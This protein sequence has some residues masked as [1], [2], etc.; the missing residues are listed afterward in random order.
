M[1][2]ASQTDCL[3]IGPDD[4]SFQ[5]YERILR[6]SGKDSPA[7]RDLN[8][9][10]LR[11]N[12]RPYEAIELLEHFCKESYI[13]K[14]LTPEFDTKMIL[15][16]AVAYLGSYLHDRNYKFEYITSVT[17]QKDELINKLQNN[18]LLTIAII[19]TSYL[20]L[21]P[22]RE[23]INLI[24]KYNNTAKIIV[25]GP[26]IWYLIRQ[27]SKADIQST[28]Q[29]LN[30]DILVDSSEGEL[31]LVNIIDAIKNG[32]S[33]DNVNNIY[34]KNSHSYIKTPDKEENNILNENLINWK[35]FTPNSQNQ[36][37]F[38]SAISCHFKCAFCD[39]PVR[40][41]NYQEMDVEYIEKEF[42]KIEETGK[43]K[44][45]RII[46]DT[47]NI[48]K[49]RFKEILLMLI[50]NQY[51]F[52]WSSFLRCQYIDD[53]IVDLMKQANC[54]A[55]HLGIESGNPQVLENMNKKSSIDAYAK[56][57]ELLNKY[58][59]YSYATFIIGFPGET[60]KTVEDTINF[61][62]ENKPTFS[63]LWPWY[64][65]PLTPI[66]EQREKYGL[67]NW[68]TNW[69]HDTMDANTAADI[70]E[71]ILVNDKI[72][73]SIFCSLLAEF[74][75]FFLHQGFSMD[76]IKNFC[77]TFNEGVKEKL[78]SNNNKE[79]ISSSIIDKMK[80]SVS[81]LKDK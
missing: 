6:S 51:S 1:N 44:S 8:L 42:N 29:S 43:I 45:I 18:N 16:L 67:S 19:T 25:G 54:Q 61:I 55:V 36:I 63:L 28:F 57:L 3:L 10:F 77:L 38:R 47:F 69:K 12:D 23:I 17:R 70:I 62:N 79:N 34:Y 35:L 81:V 72:K 52:K 27:Q 13:E 24:K 41:K 46:D 20:T 14:G 68:G 74:I 76:Q 66:W 39:F 5:R 26:F 31:T 50:K 53:E 22:I 37:Y 9:K 21:L 59:I 56:G 49:K 30:A 71:D 60:Y 2:S 80:K 65:S 58:G 15:N 11:Y 64:C 40:V 4:L 33:L 48:P 32:N 73:G 78:K 75:S 7:Y